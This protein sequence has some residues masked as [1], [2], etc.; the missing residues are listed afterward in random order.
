MGHT[1]ADA[2]LGWLCMTP[3]LV[4]LTGGIGSGKSTVA[5]MLADMGAGWVDADRC[6]HAVTAAGGIAIPELVAA[7][8]PECMGP[9]GALDRSYM[10]SL[11]FENPAAR[12]KLQTI[13]HPLIAQEIARAVQLAHQRVVVLDIPL[14]V[15]SGRWRSHCD[16]VLVVD[17]SESTQL[18]RVSSRNGWAPSQTMAVIDAQ[19]NRASR[20]A[21]ADVVIDNDAGTLQD[22]TAAV[23]DLGR[24][25]GL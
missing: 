12:A 16:W 18:R 14:L 3:T 7:F 13:T 21:S 4:G 22:L 10:R 15:E 17:C 24:W 5:G 20:L 23:T 2:G 1:P 8:G 11:V 25:L 9:D 19:A 6:A